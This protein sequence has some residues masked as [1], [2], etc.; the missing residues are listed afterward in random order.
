[1][2]PQLADGVNSTFPLDL[3]RLLSSY[4]QQPAN[5]DLL[6]RIARWD[7]A[8]FPPEV[9]AQI[10]LLRFTTDAS[11]SNSFGHYFGLAIDPRVLA[12]VHFALSRTAEHPDLVHTIAALEQF[13]KA[14]KFAPIAVLS[15]E[16]LVRQLCRALAE[17]FPMTPQL[18]AIIG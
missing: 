7:T 11:H 4:T 17:I 10:D 12:L 5:T 8:S 9:A 18:S 1:L 15:P 6:W 16:N 2:N 3:Q 14:P 13:I